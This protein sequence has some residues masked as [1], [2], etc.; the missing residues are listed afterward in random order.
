[1]TAS[2][3]FKRIETLDNEDTTGALGIHLHYTNVLLLWCIGRRHHASKRSVT[4]RSAP[5][6]DLTLMAVLPVGS[7]A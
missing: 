7:G 4:N 6:D 2:R 3:S 1:M 5:M